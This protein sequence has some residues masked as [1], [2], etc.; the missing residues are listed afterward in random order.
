[1]SLGKALG[2][3]FKDIKAAARKLE[4]VTGKKATQVKRNLKRTGALKM[5]L[6]KQDTP[7]IY[8]TR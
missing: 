2:G 4:Q 7:L 6:G 5:P 1:M 3:T 8:S